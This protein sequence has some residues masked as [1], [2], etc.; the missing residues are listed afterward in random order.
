MALAGGATVR[1]QPKNAPPR[2]AGNGDTRRERPAGWH[3]PPTLRPTREAR[4]MTPEEELAAMRRRVAEL[5]AQIAKAAP[6]PAG[7]GVSGD[8]EVVQQIT[9]PPGGHVGQVVARQEHHYH[10][11]S[12]DLAQGR[13]DV[14]GQ[15][16]G[17][18]VGVNQGTIQLFFG[19]QPPADAKPLL[20]SYLQSL[21]AEHGYLRLGK[22]LERERSGRDQAIMPEIALLKVYTTLTT[23][24][25]LPA[26]PFALKLDDLQKQMDTADPDTVLPEQVRLPI[27]DPR[28]P[29]DP[30][31]ITPGPPRPIF[32]GDRAL[33]HVWHEARRTLGGRGV[34]EG[35]WYRPEGLIVA[36]GQGQ[37]RPRLVLL[38]SPGSGKSTGLRHLTVFIATALLSGTKTLRIPFFCPL[39]PVAQALG[40]DP[41]KDV[42]T[43]VEALLRPALGAGGLRAGLRAR[44]QA[45]IIAGNAFLFFDG[46]DEVSG[47]PEPTTGGPR[48]RRERVADAIRAFAHQV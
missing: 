15:Q 12:A 41:R 46:L 30:R 18:A 2:R 40:D 33:S 8:A 7:I 39:G 24:Q 4:P 14:S 17:T 37:G 11:G 27:L 1:L 10:A 47:V 13:V 22:L 3:P 16:Y 21:V 44:V 23:D 29:D 48:S 38:G 42:D 26:G 32:L 36:I 31:G 5:E 20:D 35:Q 9:V 45:A 25:L 28:T 19:Q 43:L 34:R 6:P